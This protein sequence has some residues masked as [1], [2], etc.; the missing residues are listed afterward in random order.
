M[1]SV[2]LML[3]SSKPRFIIQHLVIESNIYIMMLLLSLRAL[4]ITGSD[5]FVNSAVVVAVSSRLR[6]GGIPM[7]HTVVPHRC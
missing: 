4:L 3:L 5:A 7:D 1:F 6:V 2:V